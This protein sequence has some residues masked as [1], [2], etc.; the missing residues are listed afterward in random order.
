MNHSDSQPDDPLVPIAFF[1]NFSEAGMACE[2]LVNNGIQ[3]SLSG[4]NFGGLEPL[5]IPG[6]FSEIRLLVP[7][8]EADR[9]LELYNA[10]FASPFP[11]E[12]A[13]EPEANHG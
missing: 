4:R 11:E 7:A 3:A 2:L 6:G 8:D 5:L 1:S 13:N 12:L 10:F 9:A